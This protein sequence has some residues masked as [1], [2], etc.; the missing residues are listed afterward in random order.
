FSGWKRMC[1][2]GAIA[3]LCKCQNSCAFLF[4]LTCPL[5]EMRFFVS[6]HFAL[7]TIAMSLPLLFSFQLKAP[8]D[9]LRGLPF[10]LIWTWAVVSALTVPVLGNLKRLTVPGRARSGRWSNQG[11]IG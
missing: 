8:P 7:L 4:S 9:L 2:M 1:P 11:A 5:G 10:M 3:C 6:R